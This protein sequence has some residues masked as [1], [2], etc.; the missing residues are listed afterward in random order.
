VARY[1]GPKAK[2]SRREGTDLFLKSARRS[3]ADKCKLDTKPG[4]HGRTSGQRTSDYGNQLREKQKVKRTYGVLE[5]QFRRY[6][7]EADR[8]KGNTGE[9]LLLLL[10]SRLDNVVYR[11]GFGSTRA[12]ARQLVSHKS[13]MLNGASVN[14][15]SLKIKDG[16]VVAVREASK[17]QLRV[18][19]S[20]TL[21]QQIGFPG[22]VSVD[23]TKMEG[24]FKHSPDR[25]DI[26]NDINESLVVELYSR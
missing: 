3:L 8:R 13:I 22:W 4:Q 26:A 2:L 23:V 12:E 25:T 21:A 9:N 24:V 7:S 18:Q 10:E 11:M 6:F 20:L 19:E 15:P 1:L 14:V 5:R 17:K 16:D